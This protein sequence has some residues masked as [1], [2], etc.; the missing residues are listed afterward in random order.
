[1]ALHQETTT[2]ERPITCRVCGS[3][4]VSKDGFY[5]DTQYY[6]C[7]FCYCYTEKIIPNQSIQKS[8]EFFVCCR[9]ESLLILLYI[10]LFKSFKSPLVSLRLYRYIDTQSMFAILYNVSGYYNTNIK[11]GRYNA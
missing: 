11:R 6:L 7:K 8:V 5:K 3:S 1:M 4:N 2:I 10:I 9:V